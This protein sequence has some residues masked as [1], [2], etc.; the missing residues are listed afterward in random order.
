MPDLLNIS[1]ILVIK[2]LIELVFSITPSSNIEAGEEL[3]E[4]LREWNLKKKAFSCF[5]VANNWES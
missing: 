3:F 4:I 2:M 5:I 1:L